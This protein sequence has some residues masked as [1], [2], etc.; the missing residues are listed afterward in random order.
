MNT[1][2]RIFDIISEVGYGSEF[3]VD[4]DLANDLGFDSLDRLDLAIK[5]EKEFCITIPDEQFDKVQT[6]EDVVKLVDSIIDK[7]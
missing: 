4:C 5:L 3:T 1:Q 6:V 2:E 7:Q